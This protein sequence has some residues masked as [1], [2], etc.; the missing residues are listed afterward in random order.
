MASGVTWAPSTSVRSLPTPRCR[1]SGGTFRTRF[2]GT[3]PTLALIALQLVIFAVPGFL[4]VPLQAGVPGSWA[5]GPVPHLEVVV[6]P[7]P[8]L[9]AVVPPVTQPRSVPLRMAPTEAGIALGDGHP[10]LSE[11]HSRRAFPQRPGTATAVSA[12]P[13]VVLAASTAG[14]GRTRPV[15]VAE[16]VVA[17]PVGT[18]T[19]PA[20][21]QRQTAPHGRDH[22][23]ALGA[24]R[25]ND[26]LERQGHK[27]GGTPASCRPT[28]RAGR[29]PLPQRQAYGGTLAA[30]PP[31]DD[32]GALT[33][34]SP[35]ATTQVARGPARPAVPK[36]VSRRT[37]ASSGETSRV[38][39]V[40]WDRGPTRHADLTNSEGGEFRSERKHLCSD[41]GRSGHRRAR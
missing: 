19:R 35:S 17:S 12:A 4:F 16:A 38:T 7:V 31:R 20:H 34:G 26:L 3:V 5:G 9:E 6:P 39:G 40:L 25:P 30:P 14:Q 13:T 33:C 29:G 32:R 41:P 15:V 11:P 27:P 2:A 36:S 1:R 37:S 22:A 28:A 24:A 23:Q 18:Q 8:H 21:G 10:E